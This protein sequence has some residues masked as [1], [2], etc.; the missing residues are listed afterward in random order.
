MILST[1]LFLWALGL[2]LLLPVA[3]LRAVGRGFWKLVT[4]IAAVLL[5]GAA[6]AGL[7][8][9]AVAALVREPFPG[10]PEAWRAAA[11]L[12]QAANLVCAL[13]ATGLVWSGC[14]RAARADLL[15]ANCIGIGAVIARGLGLAAR[16]GLSAAFTAAAVAGLLLSAFTLGSVAGGMLLGHWYLVRP[17]LSFRYLQIVAG[18][19]VAVLVARLVLTAAVGVACLGPGGTYAGSRLEFLVQLDP[20]ALLIRGTFGLLG[21]LVLSGM[22]WQTVKLRANQPATGL[23]YACVVLVLAGELVA[24]YLLTAR[25]APL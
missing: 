18:I 9:A 12:L 7:D 19:L 14:E 1:F 22:I 24:I 3:P 2:L 5:L 10:G 20:I 13:A 25:H 21:P 11:A 23:L 17:G 8:L 16:A 6:Q 4:L 15:V